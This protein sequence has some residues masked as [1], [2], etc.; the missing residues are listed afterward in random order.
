VE[1]AATPFTRDCRPGQVLRLP[2]SHGQGNFYADQLTLESLEQN[3]QVVFRYCAPDG[4]SSG[5]AN[6]NGSLS[7]IAGICNRR[8]NVLGMMPHPERACEELLGGSDGLAIFRSAIG[9]L[10]ALTA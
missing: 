6:P 4:R 3:G 2:I 7:A 1:Q 10:Q 8:G 9:S 5:A